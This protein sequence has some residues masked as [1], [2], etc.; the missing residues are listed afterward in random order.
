METWDRAKADRE[1]FADY[2]AT[3]TE[4]DFAAPSW[5]AGWSVKD[6]TTHLLVSST[7]SKG[8]VFKLLLA[9]GFNLDKMS[10]KLTTRMSGEMS[11]EQVVVATRSTAGVRSAPPGL[12]PVG[13]FAELVTHANDIFDGDRQAVPTADGIRCDRARPHE[14][15]ATGAGLQETDRRAATAGDRHRVVDRKRAAGGGRRAAPA[16]R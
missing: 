12:K 14:G 5:C 10:A 13:V 9:P 8:Q 7:M 11:N 16:R 15:R 2:L 6:V 3:L 1:A 4:Q